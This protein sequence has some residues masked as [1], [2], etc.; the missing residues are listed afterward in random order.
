MEIKTEIEKNH[1]T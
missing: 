1:C